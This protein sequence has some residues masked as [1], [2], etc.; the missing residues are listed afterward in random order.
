MSI[1]STVLPIWITDSF[2]PA[3][4]RSIE[5]KTELLSGLDIVK[6]PDISVVF[7]S[8]H[9]RAGHVGGNWKW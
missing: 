9:I 4:V 6:K 8:D 7:G 2:R 5:E 3:R 1:Q